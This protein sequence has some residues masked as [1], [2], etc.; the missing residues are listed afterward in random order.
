MLEV[1]NYPGG[2]RSRVSCYFSIL[3][4]RNTS[5]TLFDVIQNARTEHS[6]TTAYFTETY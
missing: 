6:V 4:A 5:T 1:A 2:S 3:F